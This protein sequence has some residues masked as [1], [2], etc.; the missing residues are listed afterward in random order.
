MAVDGDSLA[1]RGGGFGVPFSH[2]YVE[3]VYYCA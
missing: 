1:Y 3:G 2:R